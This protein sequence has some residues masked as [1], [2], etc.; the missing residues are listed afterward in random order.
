MKI[1]KTHFCSILSL[2]FIL[3]GCASQSEEERVASEIPEKASKEVSDTTDPL[4]TKKE[5]N[6]D[7]VTDL[8]SEKNENSVSS[9]TPELLTDILTA[10]IAS[11]RN[12]PKVALEALSRAVYASGDAR[13]NSSAI[14]L[15]LQLRDYP[16]AIKLSR[17]M[18]EQQPENF[19]V[20]LALANALLQS[21]RLDDASNELIEL[22]KQ[23]QQGDEPVLQEVASL[24]TRQEEGT[25]DSLVESVHKAA[26]SEHPMVVFTAALLASRMEQEPLFREY[27]EESLRLSPDWETA[28]ILK[29]T[30]AADQKNKEDMEA[31]AKRFLTEY[32]DA[33]RFRL[34]YARLLIQDDK[35]ESALTSLNALLKINPSSPEGL[36]T[37]GLVNMDLENYDDSIEQFKAYIAENDNTDQA[38]LYLS[39]IYIEQEAY[40]QASP[41]L[42][43]IN[44]RRYYIDAQVTLSTVIAKQSNVEAGLSY[45]RNI[46]VRG[47]DQIVRLILE[48][49][50][51]LREFDQ[52]N[53]SFS[54][55]GE[56]L[57]AR[58]DNPDL[59]YSRG[60]LA[61]QLDKL[62]VV[63]R[64]LKKLIEIQPDNAHAYNALGYT[65]ADQTER[66][67]EALELISKALEFLPEDAFI[68]DSM[69]W[70]HYRK[71]DLDKALS[72][73]QRALSLR[74]DAEIAAHLGEVLWIT[75]K[76]SEAEEVWQKGKSWDQENVTLQKTIDRFLGD[77]AEQATTFKFDTSSFLA[78]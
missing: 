8:A 33:D 41:L 57:E 60:L 75:G 7:D 78:A 20:I 12:Q 21:D 32:P 13:L 4:E 18:L 26:E 44:S 17:L 34:Q 11:Q 1:P 65:L 43:R 37:A 63:E 45:L 27:L 54:L 74:E 42:R 53:R 69:G 55:L 3:S 72:F 71:G 51:L 46:D 29:L 67:D 49:D 10:S 64:D 36:F 31:W 16:E 24:I 47:E 15:A 39:Q 5:G 48:Q 52:E 40:S 50:S 59:L 66:Y 2:I 25:R 77:D 68:L 38:K 6:T 22:V 9:L 76:R 28:A 58:P 73:L 30:D 14:Q 35:L 23:Q 19:R 70:V 56:A 61:A 62:D